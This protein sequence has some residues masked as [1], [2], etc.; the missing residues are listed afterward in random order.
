MS[1]ESN[2]G[3]ITF[4][5]AEN[6]GAFLQAYALYK[7][8]SNNYKNGKVKVIDYRSKI[9]EK[10]YKL[11][12]L[13]DKDK[14]IYNFLKSI[15]LL[16]K[17]MVRKNNFTQFRNKY[18]DT[19]KSIYNK[20][21]ISTYLKD[22]KYLITGSDQVWNDDITRD[23]KSL[24]LLYSDANLK[25][26]KISYAASVGSDKKNPVCYKNIAAAIKDYK[27][28]SVREE[29]SK[30]NLSEYTKK[31]IN[32]CLDPVLLHSSKFW[33]GIRRNAK[34]KAKY[35]FV[36][37]I[38]TDYTMISYAEKIAREK[39]LIIVHVDKKDRY[40]CKSKSMYHC[41]PDV[42]V[43]L[44]ANAEYVLTNSFHGLAFSIVYKKKFMIFP[45][46][47]RNSRLENLLKL[48]K[49]EERVYT[50]TKQN[51]CIDNEIDYKNAYKELNKEQKKSK[52]FIYNAL[53]IRGSVYENK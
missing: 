5:R 51:S 40:K 47:E 20:D 12:Y 27:M 52:E 38:T 45:M 30:N 29:L 14:I 7:E 42:F 6:Y 49:L 48:S 34:I 22:Y 43:D 4:H 41:G 50:D 23:D 26:E 32:V 2:V 9:I 16:P 15:I 46:K 19:T 25:C 3:I 37:T 8:I 44:I 36:Y 33:D 1:K 53:D 10:P 13:G 18:I 28:V 31:Q 35:V 21:N 17:N 24:Y 39:G 11:I